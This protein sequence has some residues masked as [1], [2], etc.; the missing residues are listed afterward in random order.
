MVDEL[1]LYGYG[2]VAADGEICFRGFG[3][4]SERAFTDKNRIAG[5]GY[6]GVDDRHARGFSIDP[7]VEGFA[8]GV[9]GQ[10]GL[11]GNVPATV[12]E[13]EIGT[14]P[15]GVTGLNDGVGFFAYGLLEFMEDECAPR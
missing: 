3:L 4:L 2:R 1:H 12:V 15:D 7:K 13:L 8:G 6:A 11:Q 14:K 9:G 10:C 5:N